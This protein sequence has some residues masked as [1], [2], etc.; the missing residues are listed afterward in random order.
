MTPNGQ[1]LVVDN[2][3]VMREGLL[4][5]VEPE[6]DLDVCGIAADGDDAV[7]AVR[8]HDPR[9]VLIDVSVCESNGIETTCR[10]LREHPE[11]RVLCFSLNADR[12]QLAALLEAGAAG[13]LL[14]SAEPDEV[15]MAIRAVA[16]GQTYLSPAVTGDLVRDFVT[17]RTGGADEPHLT[18]REYEVLQLIAEGLGT[19]GVA[20]RLSISPKTVNTHREHIMAKLDLHTDV[21]LC[22]YALRS[23]VVTDDLDPHLTRPDG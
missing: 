4:A 7:A 3:P 9:V 11:V 12:Q 19:G 5:L 8:E 2:H 1:L 14:W 17:R 21:A 20:A 10:I 18:P 23:G 15:L 22:R 6:P 13:Y 16:A